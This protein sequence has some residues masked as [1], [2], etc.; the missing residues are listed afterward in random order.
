MMAN[1]LKATMSPPLMMMTG[2][3]SG[4]GSGSGGTV[5]ST[6]RKRPNAG[7]SASIDGAAN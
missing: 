4:G 7:K 2:D 5:L 6:K 3:S 1:L